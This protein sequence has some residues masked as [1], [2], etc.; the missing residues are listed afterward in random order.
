LADEGI[1]LVADFVFNHTSD[2]QQWARQAKAGDPD[3]Q[4]FYWVFND[5]AGTAVYQ[6]RLRD[7]FPTV[8]K[9]S[10]T[11][12]PDMGKW[13]WTTFNSFQRDLN[14]SNPAVFRAM[15]SE[16][17]GLANRGV[18]ALRLDAV[19]F[20]WKQAGTPCENLPRRIR[21]S[22]HSSRSQ[23]WPAPRCCSSRRRLSTLTTSP[24]ISTF[25]NASCR[26]TRC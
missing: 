4:E 11:W 6:A 3:H 25:V 26:T 9:G 18:A 1:A 24:G 5:K 10:F 7:I 8:R 17:I 19:A 14:Y 16:M 23:G 20:I 2:E 12:C 15:A 21:S 22:R 13:V